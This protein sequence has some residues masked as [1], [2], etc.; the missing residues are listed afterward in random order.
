MKTLRNISKLLKVA[1][2]ASTF[3][4]TTILV[5]G[6]VQA[7]EYPTKPVKLMVGW[8]AGGSTDVYARS[9]ASF[10]NDYLGMP[11][12]VV[13]KPG[14]SG[15]IAG[16]AAMAARPD[17][18]TLYVQ[19]GGTF[20]TRMRIDGE[21]SL[22]SAYDDF[23]PLGS[24]GKVV[25]GLIVPIDSPFQTAADLVEFAKANPGKLRWA[26]PGRG[27]LH[28][29]SGRIFL[30][31]NDIQ[32]Q[33]VPF[34]GGS[35]ARNAVAGKQVDFGFMGISLLAGFGEKLRA[36]GVTDGQRD[37]IYV[38]VP[39]FGEQG[40]PQMAIS[41]PLII[42]GQK[43]LPA[44]IVAKLTKAIAEAA[45][46]KGYNKMVRKTGVAGFYSTPEESLVMVKELDEIVTPVVNEFFHN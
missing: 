41:S 31:G 10:V 9:L 6:A 14:A 20:V 45:Q 1:I 13:N 25:T 38:D 40:L 43:D 33:D 37:A 27:S 24:I 2:V 35:K 19:S 28:T 32:A 18:Y 26:N 5:S 7:E 44:P 8:S 17:G 30:K 39:T 21:K 29:L 4:S 11:M 23:Q 36:L 12:V 3:I 16:K 34:K 46:S 15:M 22:V 42:W